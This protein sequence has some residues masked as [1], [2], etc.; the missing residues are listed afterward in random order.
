M[1]LMVLLPTLTVAKGGIGCINYE[2]LVEFLKSVGGGEGDK[3]AVCTV[4]HKASAK[5]SCEAVPV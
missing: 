3:T 4:P 1:G 2:L 5:Q